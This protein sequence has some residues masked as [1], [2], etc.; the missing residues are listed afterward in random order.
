[1]KWD[2][3][4]AAMKRQFMFIRRMLPQADWSNLGSEIRITKDW[5]NESGL[6]NLF[7]FN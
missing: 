6:H 1:M 2:K 7:T 3:I 5:K 4:S